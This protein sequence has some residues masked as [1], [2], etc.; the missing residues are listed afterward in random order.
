MLELL[1]CPHCQVALPPDPPGVL[2]CGRCGQAYTILAPEA[3]ATE[4]RKITDERNILLLVGGAMFM[5]YVAPV[6]LTLLYLG[7][8]VFIY[9]L[10]FIGLVASGGMS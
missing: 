7:V 1:A 3:L 9:L 6:L 5:L 2:H 10:V 4:R 8:V